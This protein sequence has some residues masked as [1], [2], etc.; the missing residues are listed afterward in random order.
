MGHKC[1]FQERNKGQRQRM[2]AG[3]IDGAYLIESKS[4]ESCHQNSLPC[5][6]LAYK[7]CQS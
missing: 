2:N 7:L 1:M 3:V 5:G 6:D 4:E